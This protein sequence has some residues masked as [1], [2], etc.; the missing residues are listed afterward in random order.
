M[1]TRS[2]RW[3]LRGGVR[4]I[5]CKLGPGPTPNPDPVPDASKPK[6]VISFRATFRRVTAETIRWN[7]T[8]R[9]VGGSGRYR[10]L[11]GSGSIAGS[12]L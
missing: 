8:L 9:I 2:G 7:G 11:T 4:L 1:K 12:F 6:I 10:G 5:V 3:E